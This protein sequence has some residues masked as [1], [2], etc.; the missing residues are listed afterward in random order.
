MMAD[1]FG[2]AEMEAWRTAMLRPA[3]TPLDTNGW[4]RLPQVDALQLKAHAVGIVIRLR[5]EDGSE[6]TFAI[7]PIA[8]RILAAAIIGDAQEAGWMDKGLNVIPRE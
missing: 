6:Y 3:P 5:A 7:N 1:A 8:A 2:E 4:E